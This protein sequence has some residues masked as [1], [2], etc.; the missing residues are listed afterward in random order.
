MDSSLLTS[1]EEIEGPERTTASSIFNVN[2]G[3]RIPGTKSPIAIMLSTNPM[4]F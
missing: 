2:M 4:C 3:A 1:S